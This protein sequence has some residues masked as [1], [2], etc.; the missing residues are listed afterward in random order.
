MNSL[1]KQ[2]AGNN[3]L[4]QFNQFRQTFRGDPKAEIDRLINSGQITQAQLNDAQ[5]QAQE[6]AKLLGMGGR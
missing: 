5:R 2:L 4:E 6:L 3:V 1:Y